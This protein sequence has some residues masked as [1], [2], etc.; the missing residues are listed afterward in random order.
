MFCLLP[1]SCTYYITVSQHTQ[2]CAESI[3]TGH[4]K[5]FGALALT[6]LGPAQVRMTFRTRRRS[7]S[8]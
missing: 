5:E 6:C 3:V 8:R 7:T 4:A 2:N 1:T